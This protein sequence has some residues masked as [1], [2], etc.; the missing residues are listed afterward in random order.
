MIVT[1]LTETRS[2]ARDQC[3]TET[4]TKF[5]SSDLGN[6]NI[7]AFKFTRITLFL[8]SDQNKQITLPLW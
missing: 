6:A 3:N 2:E 4:K 7:A 1:F 8:N 5:F